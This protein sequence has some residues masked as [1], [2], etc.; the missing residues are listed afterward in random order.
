M[1]LLYSMISIPAHMRHSW[2]K[3]EAIFAWRFHLYLPS[4]SAAFISSRWPFLYFHYFSRRA[5]DDQD[6]A[7]AAHHRLAVPYSVL[8]AQLI[9]L[10]LLVAYRLLYM[11]HFAFASRAFSSLATIIPVR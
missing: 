2:R 5:N 10:C 9:A 6:H 11:P 3:K 7:S 8:R 4:I 1:S